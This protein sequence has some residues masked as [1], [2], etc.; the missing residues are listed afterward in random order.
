MFA[1]GAA[2]MTALL[3]LIAELGCGL[4]VSAFF[5]KIDAFKALVLSLSLLILGFQVCSSFLFAI[6]RFSFV[7]T[8]ES[9]I[10]LVLLLSGILI[11][12]QKGKKKTDFREIGKRTV[13][14]P[15]AVCL[16]VVPMSYKKAGLFNMSQD[17]G[18]YQ[19]EAISFAYGNFDVPM[20]FEEYQLLTNDNEREE[21][22]KLANPYAMYG[23]YRL[24]GRKD[25]C[26]LR[27]IKPTSDMEG[28]FH[29][30]HVYSALL[31]L[32]SFLFGIRNMLGIQTFMLILSVFLFS[33]AVENVTDNKS[34]HLL[35]T[36]LF[37]L[38][39]LT[40]W[41]SKT[42]YSE[43]TLTLC[44]CTYL[45]FVTHECADTPE[46][47][48]GQ[49]LTAACFAFLHIIFLVFYPFFFAVNLFGIKREKKAE[50]YHLINCFLMAGGMAA[51]SHCMA[52]SASQ[53]YY[54][55]M[56]RLYWGPV[57]AET[58]LWW[59]DAGV[60]LSAVIAVLVRNSR[61]QVWQKIMGKES[62]RPL[63]LFSVAALLYSAYCGYRIGYVKTELRFPAFQEEYYYQGI[64]AF[65]HLSLF[66]LT[67]FTGFFVLPLAML[68][69]FSETPKQETMDFCR[70]SL[71]ILFW[72]CVI[73][74][75]AVFKTEIIY[76]MYYAR[77]FTYLIP[78]ILL[79]TVSFLNRSG[80]Y[81]T[82]GLV[83]CISAAIMLYM[84]LDLINAQEDTMIQWSAVEEV[85][86]VI[87]P[88]SAVIFMD[89][90][91][92]RGFGIPIRQIASAAVFP[93]FEDINQEKERLLKRYAH[94]YIFG[95][96][97]S[98]AMYDEALCP[99]KKMLTKVSFNTSRYIWHPQDGLKREHLKS[100]E[101]YLIY[102]C[103]E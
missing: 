57:T 61:A 81:R 46:L 96:A 92:I 78:L 40:L 63:R 8:L 24:A 94:V 26:Q 86:E 97:D 16:L 21:Y 82:W 33:F 69:F 14:I 77:Y 103:S 23:Y 1:E 28:T 11:S 66:A 79:Y 39:P 32:W 47:R 98:S 22:L 85:T 29:G 49:G 76:Y 34:L 7:N 93:K 30:N 36:L 101:S 71:V 54:D 51:A 53:Y 25:I 27:G 64:I 12:A 10:F 6:N 90:N 45:F 50:R 17:E 68:Q 37:A 31:G 65:T 84:D 4:T 41:I 19:A 80:D 95:N 55:N 3:V 75:A 15:L 72:G 62:L 74:Y 70:G 35:I 87:E 88:N 60:L 99:G 2:Q 5:K 13:L 9:E 67:V 91:C 18:V 38:S 102:D 100:T 59:I 44:M 73:F 48:L 42:A 43:M 56:R 52:L 89:G 83:L 20:D 58:I